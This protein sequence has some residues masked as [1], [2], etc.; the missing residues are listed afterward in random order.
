MRLHYKALEKAPFL[1]PLF[2]LWRGV[3]TLFT[4]H[5]MK[6]RLQD[7]KALRAEDAAR[8]NAALAFVGLTADGGERD[9]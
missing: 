5:K 1:L 6:E 2:W 3:R 8:H 4:P 7:V 9:G